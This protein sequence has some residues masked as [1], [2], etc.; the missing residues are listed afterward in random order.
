MS[1]KSI[2]TV[3]F[4]V[5]VLAADAVQA[6]GEPENP[7]G[8]LAEVVREDEKAVDLP[9]MV[10]TPTRTPTPTR[11]AASSIT[12]ISQ[13]MIEGSNKASV[14]EILK[15]VPALDVVRTGGP[16]GTT[17]VF[18]RGAKSEHTLVLID[19]VEMNDP[20][21][22]GRTFNF[23]N[24][25]SDNIE[26]IEI[27]RGPQSV[28]Y[29]SD[30]IGGVINI[31]TKRGKGRPCLAVLWEWGSFATFREKLTF[32]GGTKAYHYSFSLSRLD[33]AGISAAHAEGG[34]LERDGLGSTNVSTKLGWAPSDWLE[35]GF[36]FRYAGA[37]IDIDNHGGA[38]GDDPNHKVDSHQLFLKTQGSISLLE[39]LWRQ[40]I[41]FLLT[42]HSMDDVND[43]DTVHPFDMAES[44]FEGLIVKLDW[45]HILDLHKTN[46]LTFGAEIEEESGQS[47]YYSQSAWGPYTSTLDRKAALSMGFYVQDQI[48]MWDCFFTTLGLRADHH[49]RSGW[50]VTYRL[51]SAFLLDATG[52]KFKATLGSGFKSP[53]IF[54]LY[55]SYGDL[56]LE[57]EES[58][59]M[60]I[61]IEQ[62][63]MDKKII[64]GATFFYNLFD[65]L[66]DF[67][68]ATSKF[69]NVAEAESKGV[70]L[71]GMVRPMANLTLRAHFIHTIARDKASKED[72]LRRARNRFFLGADLRL[73]ARIRINVALHYIG[74]RA[75]KDF[76][77]WPAQPVTLDPYVLVNLAVSYE[78]NEN[79][80]IFCR[81]VNLL[82]EEYVEATGF[83][84][85]GLSGT[86]GFR[87][88][89]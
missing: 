21:S 72:L 16:G 33:T 27:I 88:S 79:I 52:T 10:V 12:V 82:N 11:E 18:I 3:A 63:L 62:T 51:A 84:T 48:K 22:A 86:L 34:N 39:D 66:I 80:T 38:G 65:N 29:G 32:S 36:V 15:S 67:D 76:S 68:T 28:L 53:S 31:I 17:S 57:S 58:L 47:D 23:A 73:L 81:V 1:I 71:Y 35:L 41:G 59:G 24:L 5:T 20:I 60:D 37:R 56:D 8:P 45:Q 50:V 42:Y 75:D 46:T 13:D 77:S 54:Q 9:E 30:A 61:G 4:L 40:E 74:S 6:Q 64:G 55:S 26:R 83:G 89:L 69:L 2:F 14:L 7:K 43:I 85:L 87:I 70:E 19:G 25:T 78:F 49:S 44:S